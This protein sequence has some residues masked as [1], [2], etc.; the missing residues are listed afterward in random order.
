MIRTFLDTSVLISGWRGIPVRQIKALTILSDHKREF[1]CS[2]FVQLELMTKPIW[3]KNTDELNFYEEY[4]KTVNSWVDNFAQMN[5]EAMR[6]GGKYGLGA[7]DALHIAA[8]HLTN[9]DEFI[10]AERPTSPLSR[11]KEFTILSIH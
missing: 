2:P 1:I 8:S 3:N 11:V 10:T 6:L 7:M 4:F 5:D 9:V